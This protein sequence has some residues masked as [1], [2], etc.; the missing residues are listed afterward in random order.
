[1]IFLKSL[2]FLPSPH[3]PLPP[4]PFCWFGYCRKSRLTTSIFCRSEMF[5]HWYW[6]LLGC[7]RSWHRFEATFSITHAWLFFFFLHISSVSCNASSSFIIERISTVKNPLLGVLKGWTHFSLI[8]IFPITTF[9]FLNM[10]NIL[11][12]ES[13]E[14]LSLETYDWIWPSKRWLLC[15]Q[16]DG[17]DDLEGLFLLLFWWCDSYQMGP[18]AN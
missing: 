12:T 3:S 18:R 17:W 14:L 15:W 8:E 2:L 11:P 7:S 16:E 13:V 4:P 1:M 10:V 9:A 5:K 6:I